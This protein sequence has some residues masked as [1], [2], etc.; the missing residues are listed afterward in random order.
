M[1]YE[2]WIKR[3]RRY[4]ARLLSQSPPIIASG[5]YR[6]CRECR[7]VLLCHENACPN[8]NADAVVEENIDPDDFQ[9]SIGTRIRCLYRFQ[10]MQ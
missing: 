5:T 6:V 3:E 7:E 8:C 4:R 9:N 10:T 1:D 2:Q